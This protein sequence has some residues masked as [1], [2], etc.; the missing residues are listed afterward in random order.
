VG[1][2]GVNIKPFGNF[3]KG[4]N[5]SCILALLKC[6]K[7]FCSFVSIGDSVATVVKEPIWLVL[8]NAL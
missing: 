3:C 6:H 4:S 5:P 7:A 1:V 2:N 8:I